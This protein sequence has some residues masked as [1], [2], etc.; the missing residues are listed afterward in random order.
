M[1]IVA[2][3]DVYSHFDLKLISLFHN[4]IGEQAIRHSRIDDLSPLISSHLDERM[5]KKLTWLRLD[6]HNTTNHVAKTPDRNKYEHSLHVLE[7]LPLFSH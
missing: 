2:H 6:W 3:P 7:G 1:T 5:C 4:K